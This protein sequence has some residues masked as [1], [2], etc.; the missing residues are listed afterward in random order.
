MFGSM[1]M[2]VMMAFSYISILVAQK[3]GLDYI[4]N[5]GFVAAVVGTLIVIIIVI[6]NRIDY[7]YAIAQPI[8][9]AGMLICV[10]GMAMMNGFFVRAS[11]SVP[12]MKALAVSFM[13]T[14]NNVTDARGIFWSSLFFD[15]TMVPV[16]IMMFIIL[17][18]VI[19]LFVMLRRRSEQ[20]I[21]NSV[22]P[23]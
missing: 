2:L 18:I 11:N 8:S 5:I 21:H 19:T 3:K 4:T 1:L 14:L 9:A 6:F 22:M 20:E 15:N 16:I 10:A 7:N 13:L 12:G 23:K 17:A